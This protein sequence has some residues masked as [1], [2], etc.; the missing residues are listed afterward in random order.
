MLRLFL[1]Q[2][3]VMGLVGSLFGSALGALFLI[4][5]RG[6][7]KNADGTQMFV[8]TIEPFVVR[9]GG[10]GRNADRRACGNGASASRRKARSGGG[11]PWMTSA[12]L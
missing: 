8:I 11:D 5:W 9:D 7:A 10:G 3:G 2:G 4:F 1:I 6:M 12:P